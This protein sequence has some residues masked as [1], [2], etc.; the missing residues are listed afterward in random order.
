MERKTWDRI[1]IRTVTRWK[2]AAQRANLAEEPS[3]GRREDAAPVT[4]NFLKLAGVFNP[5]SNSPPTYR[6]NAKRL[7]R[8][9][10]PLFGP[11]SC[12]GNLTQSC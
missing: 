3:L 6:T 5:L 8:V 1:M 2:I 7:G 9:S 10:C 12:V 4:S 11:S